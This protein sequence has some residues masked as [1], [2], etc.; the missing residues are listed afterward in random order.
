[1]MLTTKGRY[2]VMA[3]VDIAYYSKNSSPIALHEISDRQNI[4]ISY[5]E[6]LFSKLKQRGLVE[7]VKGPR[8]GYVLTKSPKGITIL[9]VIDAVGELIKMTRCAEDG[10]GG[11]LVTKQY[12][13]EISDCSKENTSSDKYFKKKNPICFTHALWDGLGKEIS[14]YLASVSLEDVCNS[15]DSKGLSA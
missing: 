2:A 12:S 6:Q 1:M 11:C 8:G 15:I 14:S 9:E 3:M 4:T 10:E 7:G 5:L 13:F